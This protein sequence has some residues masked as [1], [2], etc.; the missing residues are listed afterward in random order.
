MKKNPT[1]PTLLVE[2]T[3]RKMEAQ[4]SGT[5]T[6]SFSKFQPSKLRNDKKS[7]VGPARGGRKGN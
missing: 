3:N 4:N 6:E 5:A 7:P 2:L 1:K